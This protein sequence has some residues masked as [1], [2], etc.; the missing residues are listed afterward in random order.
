MVAVDK[1]VP[2]LQPTLLYDLQRKGK[3]PGLFADGFFWK[4]EEASLDMDAGFVEGPFGSGKR[5]KSLPMHLEKRHPAAHLFE[6]AVWFSPP[7]V[8][9]KLDRQRPAADPGR[10]QAQAPDPFDLLFRKLPSAIVHPRAPF[11]K[12]PVA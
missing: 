9:A 6:P 8:L 10:L 7:P 3:L 1:L 11:T 2:Q 4:G 5:D 12:A